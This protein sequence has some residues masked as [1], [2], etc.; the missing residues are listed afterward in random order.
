M[1]LY[2]TSN[3]N[4]GGLED[5]FVKN[6]ANSF[7]IITILLC[8]FLQV[9]LENNSITIVNIEIFNVLFKLII[10]LSLLS[11]YKIT[12]NSVLIY[13][14][15]VVGTILMMDVL[16]LI[17]AV[18]EKSKMLSSINYLIHDIM[19]FI[20]YTAF[21]ILTRIK[22]GMTKKIL[23][24]LYHAYILLPTIIILSLFC[25]SKWLP[26]YISALKLQNI[27][28]L[29][30]FILVFVLMLNFVI[31]YRNSEKLKLKGIYL[32]VIMANLAFA[33]SHIISLAIIYYGISYKY[34]YALT[35]LGMAILCHTALKCIFKAPIDDLSRVIE[36]KNNEMNKILDTNIKLLDFMPEGII[37]RQENK[38]LFSNKFMKSLVKIDNLDGS[39]V[40]K[41]VAKDYEKRI[42]E[43][44]KAA[45]AGRSVT[46]IEEEVVCF[47]GSKVWVEV[48][49]TKI[50]VDGK[51]VLLSFVR[52]ISCKKKVE[53]SE[54]E[55]LRAKTKDKL[56][57]EF[58]ANMSHELRTPINV[59]YSS[60]QV[61]QLHAA[62]DNIDNDK[63]KNYMKVIKQN[64]YRLLRIISNLIDITK[65][66]AGFLKP[67]T[68][69]RE[70][71]G[72]VENIS[73]SIV[74]YLHQKDMELIFDTDVEEKY[75]E[76]DAEMIERVMLNLFSNAVKF[77]RKNGHVWVNIHDG[78]D[79]NIIIEV[80]DD[81][82]GIPKEKQNLIFKR[83][84]QVDN[85]LIRR[86]Q[87][88]G[89]GLSLVKSIVEMNGG[90]I[91]FE[92]EENIGTTFEIKL[93]IVK[94]EIIDGYED[95]KTISDSGISNA[96]EK[97]N[98]EFADILN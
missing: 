67:N 71:V 52:D 34:R 31:I 4:E 7:L 54:K 43:Y 78:H 16:F 73:M 6:I 19:D 40:Q 10:F 66:D 55:L 49:C 42:T 83:F 11:A 29:D 58:F 63:I 25:I 22:K 65:I 74:T 76:C 70:I 87:G 59:I 62:K 3:R 26:Y 86:A 37:I 51:D 14:E 57:G 68:T 47:D 72:L 24:R 35:L 98:I 36:E 28:Y 81:G 64:C 12:H 88:S 91:S 32:S 97:V 56:R 96:A 80:K 41:L 1:D 27:F 18:E 61:M 82:I 77:R 5:K 69:R 75:A 48:S 15:I 21:I 44:T 8:V 23:K 2:K 89:I 93:P 39:D 95:L 13:F 20:T 30:Q 79:G 17:L 94:N 90:S 45:Y 53:E 33:I 9:I 92:S 50:N 38:I 60:L 85:S 46:D 84:S